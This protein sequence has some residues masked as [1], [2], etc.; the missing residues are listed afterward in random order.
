M[1]DV[2]TAVAASTTVFCTARDLAR[3]ISIS[4]ILRVIR[5]RSDAIP[6]TCFL[7]TSF[8]AVFAF[9][10]EKI[11]YD[12]QRNQYGDDAAPTINF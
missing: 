11:A 10:K 3:S 1:P 2:F 9:E 7:E 5:A 8:N 4:R 12:G 6:W